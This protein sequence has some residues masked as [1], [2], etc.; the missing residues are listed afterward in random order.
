M[1]PARC[2]PVIRVRNGSPI[3][4]ECRSTRILLDFRV[5]AYSEVV[6]DL[7][8]TCY[9]KIVNAPCFLLILFCWVCLENQGL[10]GTPWFPLPRGMPLVLPRQRPPS[11]VHPNP[12][13]D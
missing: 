5:A 3:S 9:S 2:V 12:W 13:H 1:L 11:P 4:S 10:K 8:V 7:R 6:S